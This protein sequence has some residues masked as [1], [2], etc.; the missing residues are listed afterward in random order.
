MDG[1]SFASITDAYGVDAQISITAGAF[2]P[3][4]SNAYGVRS[5]VTKAVGTITNAY[6]VYVD[7]VQGTNKW[8]IFTSDASTPSYFAGSVGIGTT[9]PARLVDITSTSAAPA[10]F[11]RL[12]ASDTQTV[13]PGVIIRLQLLKATTRLLSVVKKT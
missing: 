4:I 3:A 10:A 6:G 8:S 2:T 5:S 9:T 7:S 13:A 1:N 12:T 11:V